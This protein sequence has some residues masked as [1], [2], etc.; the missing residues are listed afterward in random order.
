MLDDVGLGSGRIMSRVAVCGAI[1]A[2]G[3]AVA[4]A[5]PESR[6]LGGGSARDQPET[7]ASR[8][9][10]QTGARGADLRGELTTLIR[11]NEDASTR[12]SEALGRLK[13]ETEKK[14]YIRANWPPERNI[15]GRMLKL[16]REH[17]EDATAFDALAWIAILGYNTAASD[18]AAEMLARR[19]GQD[20][21]LWLIC[22]EMRRGVISLARGTLLRAILENS[23]D[24]A[25]RGRA[26]LD[27]AEYNT[28]LANFIRILKT[29]GLKPWQ[30]QAYAEERLERFRALEALPL[31]DAAGQ[32]YQRALK[33]FGAIVP[34]KWWTVPRMVDS[35]PRTVYEPNKDVELDAG[36][37]ADR[38]RPALYELRSLGV[39]RI[40]P[41]IEGQ[42][43]GGRRFKLSDY[44]GR[45]VVLTFSG[46]WCGPCKAMYPH[47]REIVARLKT[48]PFALLSVMTDED[49]GKIR[50]E[51]ESG[52]ITWRCWWEP[53]GA[54]GPIPEAWNVRGYPTV[55]ILDHKGFIRLKFTG[56]LATPEGSA[57]SQPPIDKFIELLLKEQEAHAGPS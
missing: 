9:E 19:Y 12:Y 2:A 50:R 14:D 7:A 20:K 31:E 16:A 53:G 37:L 25:I 38:A 21:R 41:E 30:G 42:D 27:L 36:T 43:I 46:T 24:R 45:V 35:D 29:P 6:A 4:V 10:K 1:T 23:P 49:A 8:P 40:A 15:V 11:E 22:Q 39:G 51:A 47:E 48:R 56:F 55:Y 13:T 52:E 54:H 26:C 57:E 44:R 28:E 5:R 17:P 33:E 3:C 18:E 32:L 34:I